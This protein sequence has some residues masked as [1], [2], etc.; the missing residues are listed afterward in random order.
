MKMKKLC[1]LAMDLSPAAKAAVFGF[2]AL[3]I[4]GVALGLNIGDHPAAG[5]VFLTS[6]A[7]AATGSVVGLLSK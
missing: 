2:A 5:P 6:C 7:L 4:W 3:P 1:K